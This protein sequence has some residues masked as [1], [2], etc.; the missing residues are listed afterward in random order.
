MCGKCGF[1]VEVQAELVGKRAKCPNCALGRVA[2]GSVDGE[3]ASA[4]T[5]PVV[6]VARL[7]PPA[8]PLWTGQPGVLAAGPPKPESAKPQQTTRC[9]YCCEEITSSQQYGQRVV[10][11]GLADSGLGRTSGEYAGLPRLA[12][13]AGRAGVASRPR[14][15]DATGAVDAEASSPS[16]LPGATRPRCRSW[17][18]W[19]ACR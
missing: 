4:S 8:Q 14:A 12:T 13:T 19:L 9:P 6:A 3:L 18:T 1:G 5:A 15:D 7:R 10:C 11:C 17:G 2:P 16:T